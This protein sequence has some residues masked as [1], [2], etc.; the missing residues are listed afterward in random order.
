MNNYIC[1]LETLKEQLNVLDYD[2]EELENTIYIKLQIDATKIKSNYFD[3]IFKLFGCSLAI[4]FQKSIDLPQECIYIESSE[5]IKEH[6]NDLEDMCDDS[7]DLIIIINKDKFI[8]ELFK[9]TSIQNKF[10]VLLFYNE[11]ELLNILNKSYKEIE[12]KLFDRDKKT[13]VIL[14]DGTV[15]IENKYI[16]ISGLEKEGL[17]EILNQQLNIV[18]N[19]DK[20]DKVIEIRNENCH[21]V[22]ETE[23][24]IPDYLM[25][26]FNNKNVIITE[27]LKNILLKKLMNIILPFICNYT[28]TDADK[29]KTFSIINGQKKIT[30]MYNS[31]ANFTENVLTLYKLYKW[32][33]NDDSSD[34]LII[35]RNII[36]IYLCEQCKTSSYQSLINEAIEI[37]DS[38]R[39]NFEIYLKENVENYFIERNRVGNLVSNKAND[40][41]KEIHSIV[42]SMNKNLITSI[43]IVFVAMIGYSAK[44]NELIVKSAIIFYIIYFSF[45]GIVSLIYYAGR[46]KFIK[47]DYYEHIDN[48]KKILIL[49]DMPKYEGSTLETV[50]N[51]FWN[52]W[53]L[54]LITILML[55]IGGI[56][57]LCYFDKAIEIINML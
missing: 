22:N 45:T 48:F 30:I 15:F 38:T 13:V 37:D 54:Y 25:F 31:K 20:R 24:L 51:S 21:W 10:N 49:R 47:E 23:W 36:S 3:N 34:K 14:M 44:A 40:I 57:I 32:A 42:E 4:K 18:I 12:N 7:I 50:S 33:F 52:Y 1:A 56:L 17:F 55:I 29:N 8:T 43:G 28:N 16:L 41:T 46:Q 2:L 27:R 6:I 19:Q 11:A 35:L 53:I 39:S 5:D 9:E 26:D